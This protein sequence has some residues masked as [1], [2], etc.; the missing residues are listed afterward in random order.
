MSI[1]CLIILDMNFV[2]KFERTLDL[3]GGLLIY[4]LNVTY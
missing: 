1:V 2:F 4:I 3:E